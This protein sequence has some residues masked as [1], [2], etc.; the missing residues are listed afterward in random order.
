LSELA[1][2][3]K[4]STFVSKLLKWG[5]S[6]RRDFAWRRT[7]D[8]YK[9]LVAESLV[10][11]TKASQV[12]PVYLRFIDKWRDLSSLAMST[13][14]EV[15]S[16]IRPLGLEYRAKRIRTIAKSIIRLFAGRIPDNLADMKRLYGMGLG[17][18]IAH[19]VL[20]FAY[21]EDVAVVDKNVERILKRVF[22]IKT[23][24]GHRDTR[25]W[26]FAAQLV[27]KGKA[28]EFN[29]SMIDFGALVCTPRTPKCVICPMLE[30][31]DFGRLIG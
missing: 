24:N 26:S 11:R 31:C 9:V 20:C 1:K 12:E 17:D 2:L 28:G 7:K 23:R 8:P 18:Y 6:N 30:I 19:A 5:K 13:Q 10:Q 22:S 21:G 16:V 27:P 29:W 4:Q 14:G 15:K 25:V 3:T